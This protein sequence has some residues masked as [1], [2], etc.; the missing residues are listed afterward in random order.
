MDIRK[1]YTL[2]IKE[3]SLV[4]QLRFTYNTWD[5]VKDGDEVILTLTNVKYSI[6]KAMVDLANVSYMLGKLEEYS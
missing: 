4:D 3:R 5:I 6:V 2:K 1:P